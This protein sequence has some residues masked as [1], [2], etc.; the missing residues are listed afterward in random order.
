LFQKSE[1]SEAWKGTKRKT[2]VL[3]H[4]PVTKK[5]GTGFGSDYKMKGPK[6][7]VPMVGELVGAKVSSLVGEMEGEG[8]GRW[9]GMAVGATMGSAV[10]AGE[11]IKVGWGEGLGMG[12]AEG[13]GVGTW[14]GKGVGAG[15]GAKGASKVEL[16]SEVKLPLP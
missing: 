5:I 3:G 7:G 2:K 1:S 4:T 6:W 16:V 15:D 8:D 10:G 11:G 9:V 13:R 14:E 12:T